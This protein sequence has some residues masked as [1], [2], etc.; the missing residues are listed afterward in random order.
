MTSIA[1]PELAS[2]TYCLQGHDAVTHLF[3][4]ASGLDSMVLGEPHILG[5]VR[6]AFELAMESEAAGAALSRLGH[7]AVHVGKTVRTRTNLARNRLSIP[8]AA[9]DLARHHTKSWST[10]VQS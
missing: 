4:V 1:E 8:H 10:P 7:D 5:Q 3:N 9:V 6:T 2:A